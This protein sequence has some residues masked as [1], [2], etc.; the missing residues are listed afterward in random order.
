MADLLGE[1]P[2]HIDG[3]FKD[4]KRWEPILRSLPDF[5][6]DQNQ[7]AMELDALAID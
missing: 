5:G 1:R 6:V 7:D 3:L 2:N 4:L